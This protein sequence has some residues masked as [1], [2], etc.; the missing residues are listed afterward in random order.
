MKRSIARLLEAPL[1][2]KIL[3]GE[4][5]RGDVLFVSGDSEGLCLDVLEGGV[6]DSAA[7]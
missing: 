5:A 2:E 3:R 6:A 1:A 7:E 4:V